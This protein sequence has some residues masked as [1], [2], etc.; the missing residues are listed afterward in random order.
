LPKKKTA[1]GL[2]LRTLLRGAVEMGKDKDEQ[3]Q[4]RPSDG[5]ARA[6]NL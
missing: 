1:R 4:R 2:L 5:F 3:K 6:F